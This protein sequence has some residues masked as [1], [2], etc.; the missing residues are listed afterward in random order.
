MLFKSTVKLLSCKRR[1]LPPPLPGGAS[2]SH[3]P[4][5][6]SSVWTKPFPFTAFG[7]FF[8]LWNSQTSFNAVIFPQ[9]MSS[10]LFLGCLTQLILLSVNYVLTV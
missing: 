4:E 6:L 2:G 10:P 5:P 3:T 8:G 7:D 1:S 9:V